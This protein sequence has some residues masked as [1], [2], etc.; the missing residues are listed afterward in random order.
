MAYLNSQLA[1]A[2]AN[3]DVDRQKDI[4]SFQSTQTLNQM[5]AASDIKTAEMNVQAD[6]DKSIKAGDYAQASAM[7]EAQFAHDSSEAALNRTIEQEKVD[8]QGKQIDLNGQQMT[9]DQITQG[10]DKGLISA[11][12]GSAAIQAALKANGVTVQASDPL[13]DQKAIAQQWTTMQYQYALSHP[14][15]A[16]LGPDGKVDMA[17]PL[18]ETAVSNFNN[19]QNKISDPTSVGTDPADVAAAIIKNPA[20]YQGKSPATDPGLAAL[21]NGAAEWP[22]SGKFTNNTNRFDGGTP[23]SGS[24]FKLNNIVYIATS[25]VQVEKGDI[26]S[27]KKDTQYIN[28]VDPSTGY[29]VKIYSG[30]N[31]NA[32]QPSKQDAWNPSLLS[33]LAQ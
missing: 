17:N 7:Q 25:G 22:A 24:A 19:W 16:N 9:F 11:D 23:A 4:L 5:Y 29:T 8:L 20:N 12:S 15:D 18:K 31:V 6:I 27:G 13:D 2:K 26:W 32:P 28:A 33:Q 10:V 1:D 30:G 21:V 3:N 14:G